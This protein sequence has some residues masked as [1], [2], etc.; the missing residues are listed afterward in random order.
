MFF[1]FLQGSVKVKVM[2][3]KAEEKQAS[4][5]RMVKELLV[6]D[7]TKTIT[8]SVW[9]EGIQKLTI[10][11]SYTVTNTS[12]RFFQNSLKL[13]TTPASVIEE[14]EDLDIEIPVE[15]ENQNQTKEINAVVELCQLV[16]STKCSSCMK[17]ISSSDEQSTSTLIRCSS[18]GMKQ[19]KSNLI[20]TR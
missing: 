20:K 11:S 6:A 19:K 8:L 2:G 15:D 3:V 7:E 12:T 4:N 18:C 17:A 13:T 10:G 16:F 5:G 1:F 9:D 14:I